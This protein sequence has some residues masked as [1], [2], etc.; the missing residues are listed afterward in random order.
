MPQ[1]RKQDEWQWPPD[2]AVAAADQSKIGGHAETEV[3]GAAAHWLQL[4]GHVVF[5]CLAPVSNIRLHALQ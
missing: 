1:A 4:R 5:A 3:L 2:T